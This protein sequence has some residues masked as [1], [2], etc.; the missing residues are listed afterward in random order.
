MSRKKNLPLFQTSIW[1]LASPAGCGKNR[2]EPA[3]CRLV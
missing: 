3:I 2:A 1:R